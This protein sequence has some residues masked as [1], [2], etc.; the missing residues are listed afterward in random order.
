MV[1]IPNMKSLRPKS[2]LSRHGSTMLELLMVTAVVST[3]AAGAIFGVTNLTSV[4][5][6]TKLQRDVAVINRAIRSYMVNGGTFLQSE[7]TSPAV[8]LAKLKT[9]ASADSAK[10]LAGLR[11]SMADERLSF[12]MQTTLEAQHGEERA[13]FV[14][15]PVNPRFVVQKDGAPGIRRFVLDSNLAGQDFGTEER[16]VNM[17]LAKTDPWVWDYSDS[18]NSRTQ[19]GS[20]PPVQPTPTG[21]STS[22][23]GNLP[24]NPPGFSIAGGTSPLL[25][26]PQTLAL[27]PTNPAGTAQIFYSVDS[28]PFVPYSGPIEIDPGLTVTTYSMSLDPDHFDDSIASTQTYLATPVQPEAALAFAQSSYNYFEL[29]GAYAPGVVSAPPPGSVSGTGNM[30]NLAEIPLPYQNSTAFRY[31]WTIDGTN[32]LN[33]PT[34]QQ[35]ADFSEGFAPVTVPLPLAAFGTDPQ[36]VVTAAFKSADPQLVTDSALVTY[37]LSAVSLPLSPPVVSIDG[38][39]VTLS[40]DLSG[41]NLPAGTRIYYTTDGTDPGVDAAGNPIQ[42]ILYT[43][44]SF[45]IEGTTGTEEV[46]T[47][48]VYPPV[49]YPQFFSASSAAEAKFVLPSETSVYVGGNFVNSGIN[50]MRNIA[51]LNNSGQV[52]PR[53][54]TGSGASNGSLVGVVRQSPAGVIVGGDFES[55]NGLP[56]RG[57]ARL[58]GNGSVDPGFDAA[59]SNE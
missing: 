50:A 4:V 29:G 48:R 57:V 21:P 55:V 27:T 56:R 46:I 25:A 43:G 45:T 17:K 31:V 6:T 58:N 8:V 52:D 32:P 51:R 11:H 54:D 3:L 34:A 36:V 18:P 28:G 33:S 47:A 15:D 42:G 19:P 10:Q 24:L 7:L 16:A 44:Q 22:D 13:C 59:L 39:D 26:F 35:Q 30:V 12:E 41:Q 5:E 53:F 20:P 9:R 38:R 23:P 37:S 14:P 2:R 49:A 40:L 1:I